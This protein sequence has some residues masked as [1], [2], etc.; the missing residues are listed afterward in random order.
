VLFFSY[1]ILVGELRG[2]LN[3]LWLATAMAVVVVAVRGFIG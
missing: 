1:E 2:G 3:K